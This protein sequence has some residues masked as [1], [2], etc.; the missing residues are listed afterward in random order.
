A[1]AG[2]RSAD[3]G[4]HGQRALIVACKLG[5]LRHGASECQAR[6]AG[7]KP[8][9]SPAGRGSVAGGD[10]HRDR[11]LSCAPAQVQRKRRSARAKPPT[12][13]T[14]RTRAG[15]SR[16]VTPAPSMEI[17]R[18]PSIREVS[19]K[20]RI[21]GWD[22]PGKWLAEKKTPESTVIGRVTRFI[23]PLAV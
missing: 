21:S 4:E 23:R 10:E 6:P 12:P 22:Q 5:A 14:T 15:T 19:G 11:L 9:G 16:A 13:Q 3:V 20:A 8:P 18:R 17:A 2:Q 1:P 7:R